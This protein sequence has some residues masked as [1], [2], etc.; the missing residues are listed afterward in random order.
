M[1]S[2]AA[3]RL[4]VRSVISKLHL[5]TT[6]RP[7]QAA[8]AGAVVLGPRICWAAELAEF[9]RVEIYIETRN[10][11]VFGH[12]RFGIE[13]EVHVTQAIGPLMQPG[14][15]VRIAAHAW[16]AEP[17]AP[18][19]ERI[20]HL[21]RVDDGNRVIEFRRAVARSITLDPESFPL[22]PSS[23]SVASLNALARAEAMD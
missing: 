1:N 6:S 10:L 20:V 2:L 21:V 15:I 8:E 12:V 13:G 3:S 23:D 16:L 14:D 18:A 17:T 19:A 9:E 22:P 4:F 7:M 5:T 11:R